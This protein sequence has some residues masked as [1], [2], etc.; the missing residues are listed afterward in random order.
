MRL[1]LVDEHP[2]IRDALEGLLRR[3]FPDAEILVLESIADAREAV[4]RQPVDLI[5]TNL[6]SRHPAALHDLG[7]LVREAA[8]AR[9]VVFGERVAGSAFR[10]ARASGVH[11]YVPATYRPEL[12][13][14]AISL[15]LAG[16]DYFPHLPHVDPRGP[17]PNGHDLHARL[18]LR[19]RDVFQALKAGKSNKVIA[20][21]LMISVATVKQH[22]QAILKL[23]G[24]RNRTE[25]AA[26]AAQAAAGSGPP[27]NLAG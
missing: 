14:A 5:V 19:Q 15:V 17:S 25:A 22:V 20:R 13:G 27:S 2:L 26:I 4:R 1:L 23:S 8:P 7:D 11:G 10:Q 21:E 3:T 16:G 12:V 24:A 6:L 9:V 18:S